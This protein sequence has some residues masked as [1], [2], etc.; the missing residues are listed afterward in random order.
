MPANG[1]AHALPAHCARKAELLRAF[2]MA[3]L[4]HGLVQVFLQLL[5]HGADFPARSG[6]G[7]IRHFEQ[8]KTSAGPAHCLHGLA[9]S[10]QHVVAQAPSLAP[11][12]LVH[13]GRL[14]LAQHWKHATSRLARAEADD[15]TGDATG[16]RHVASEPIRQPHFI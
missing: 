13:L 1:L 11:A 14:G 16:R 3:R 6:A 12:L 9:D 7:A 10:L 2:E 5:R 8:L 15:I 4:R